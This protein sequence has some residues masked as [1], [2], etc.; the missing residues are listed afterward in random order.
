MGAGRAAASIFGHTHRAAD[1][2][3]RGTRVV[4]NPRGYPDQPVE[5]FD[6]AHVIELA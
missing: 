4:S 1:L 5:G 3:V 6:T 2:D